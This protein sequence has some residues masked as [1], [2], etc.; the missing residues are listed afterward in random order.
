MN[1]FEELAESF[2]DAMAQITCLVKT[3]SNETP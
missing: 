3:A 2:K 1:A